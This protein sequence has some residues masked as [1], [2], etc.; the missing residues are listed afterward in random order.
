MS[1]EV[2]YK[3]TLQIIILVFYINKWTR[4]INQHIL[5]RSELGFDIAI[6]ITRHLIDQKK[7]IRN[8]MFSFEI[9]QPLHPMAY[10]HYHHPVVVYTLQY[11][12]TFAYRALSSLCFAFAVCF[13]SQYDEFLNP[14]FFCKIKSKSIKTM[15]ANEISRDIVQIIAQ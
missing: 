5:K 14:L 15:E 4:C 7:K 10:H 13:V 12:S 3:F 1:M 11:T 8:V 2:S 6:F 9:T